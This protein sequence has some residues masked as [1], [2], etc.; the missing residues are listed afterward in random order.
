MS[1]IEALTK[2]YSWRRR[3]S[4]PAD[5]AVIRVE[6]PGNVLEAVLELGRALVVA[7]IEGAEVDFGDGAAA[8][9][10]RNVL[11]R[12]VPWPGMT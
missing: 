9:H 10:K 12:S 1:C 11:T 6:N 7:G 3:S 4:R 2:K 5:G 8:F